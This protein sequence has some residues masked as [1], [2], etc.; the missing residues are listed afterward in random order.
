MEQVVYDL[1]RYLPG[2]GEY[3][4]IENTS[5]EFRDLDRWIRRRLR[6][7]NYGSGN[8][9][10]LSCASYALGE[11]LIPRSRRLSCIRIAG[12]VTHALR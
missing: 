5:T 12:G 8:A 6:A 7:C 10:V 2:R 11:S 4:R 3:F 1:N 9:G